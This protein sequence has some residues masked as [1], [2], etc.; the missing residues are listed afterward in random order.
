MLF[1]WRL[2][3][4]FS[5]GVEAVS[6]IAEFCEA[7]ELSFVGVSERVCI[8]SGFGGGHVCAIGQVFCASSWYVVS[9]V[10]M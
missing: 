3:G 10:M 5:L 2:C 6:V 4:W 8:F 9:I 7:F 1:V